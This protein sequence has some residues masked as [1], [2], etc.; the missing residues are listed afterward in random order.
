MEKISNTIGLMS[1]MLMLFVTVG[2]AQEKKS[3]GEEVYKTY[4]TSGVDAALAK[5]RQLKMDTTN[6]TVSEWE[7]NDVAYRIMNEKNDLVAAEKVF[8]LNMEEYPEAANPLD[9]YG[10]YLLKKGDK[11]EAKEYFKKSIAISENSSVESERNQ[12]YPNT[13]GKLAKLDN[14][15]KQLDFLEGNWEVEETGYNNNVEAMKRKRNHKISYDEGGSALIIRYMNDENKLEYMRIFAYDA[16]DDEFDVAHINPNSPQGIQISQMK[17]KPKSNNEY[18]IIGH[19]N[20]RDGKKVNM[21]HELVRKAD[22]N[23]NWIVFEQGEN[24][25]WEKL[26]SM[27]MKKE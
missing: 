1:V 16:M 20:E 4:E 12:L 19:F 7:L 8:R 15:D 11:E 2:F 18:E 26:Y 25:Q 6:Y 13:K 5:Y 22:D 3:L 21:R 14:K 9:S 23:V 17:L 27:N 10:D 24:D